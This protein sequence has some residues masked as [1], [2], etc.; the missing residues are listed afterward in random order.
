MLRISRGAVILGSNVSNW[1][2][3]PCRFSTTT[4]LS[5]TARPVSAAAAR[6]ESSDAIDN[7]PTAEVPIRKNSRRDPPRPR[8]SP[9][10]VSMPR[11][12]RRCERWGQGIH[13]IH[14]RLCY[15]IW[16]RVSLWN[17]GHRRS[18]G[19]V[20]GIENGQCLYR[21][22]I[23]IATIMPTV[24]PTMVFRRMAVTGVSNKFEK[25]SKTEK[26]NPAGQSSPHNLP[27][28]FPLGEQNDQRHQYPNIMC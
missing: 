6:T 3:P 15:T 5:R 26:P 2:G 24:S 8:E 4:D 27:N 21:A 13:R 19:I 18:P 7:P 23:Q 16:G 10:I 25:K 14:V 11:L 20:V 28:V 22:M 1:L 17:G 9:E 12:P